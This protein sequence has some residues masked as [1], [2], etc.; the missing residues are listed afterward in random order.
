[1]WPYE[2]PNDRTEVRAKAVAG[3]D[4]PPGNSDLIV[5]M[6]SDILIPAPF[7][8]PLGDRSIGPVY[9]MRTYTYPSNGIPKVLEAWGKSIEE[10][11]KLSPLAGCWYSDVGGLNRFVHLWAYSSFEERQAVRAEA[12]AKGIWPPDSGVVPLK[13]ENKLL[14]PLS[15]SPM[16]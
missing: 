14:T 5:N 12:R 7:M 10:R 6:Q 8:T 2:D 15:F 9:E 11:E 1:M 13:Q 16:Q 3:G 4:W